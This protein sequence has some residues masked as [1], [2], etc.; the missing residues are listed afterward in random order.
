M[1]NEID[2]IKAN[3]PKDRLCLMFDPRLPNLPHQK[4]KKIKIGIFEAVF[5]LIPSNNN[6]NI[7]P[8]N[9]PK[10]SPF[11][12]EKGKSNKTTQHGPMP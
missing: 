5:K 7:K 4:P 9:E 8:K 11:L 6:P 12:S 10:D 2:P 3:K 1:P